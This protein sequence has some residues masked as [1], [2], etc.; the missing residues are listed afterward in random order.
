MDAI[1]SVVVVT[2]GNVVIIG[3]AAGMVFSS[4]GYNHLLERNDILRRD[5]S[6]AVQAWTA[7][8]VDVLL[9]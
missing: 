3:S 8:A 9:L 7:R 4:C 1:S 5:L 2:L 6:C